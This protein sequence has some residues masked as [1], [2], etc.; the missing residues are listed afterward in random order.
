PWRR[1]AG[2]AC[3]PQG[4][5]A[6]RSRRRTRRPTRPPGSPPPPPGPGARASHL[7]LPPA[8]PQRHL[9]SSPARSS[10]LVPGPPVE[11]RVQR[12][13]EVTDGALEAAELQELVRAAREPAL[14]GDR[15]RAV[16]RGAAV[17]EVEPA[18]RRLDPLLLRRRLALPE[19]VG[20][21]RRPVDRERF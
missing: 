8:W 6:R 4:P 10:A 16:P 21:E 17:H 18:S 7:R 19:D 2:R 20:D 14:D 11:G 3:R 12:A 15:D 1:S 13:V 5:R 9:L